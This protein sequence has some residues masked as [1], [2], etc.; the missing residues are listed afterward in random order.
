MSEKFDAYQLSEMGDVTILL[1]EK[2]K[3]NGPRM[4]HM[5]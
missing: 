4:Y 5:L 3:E 1:D 2:Q